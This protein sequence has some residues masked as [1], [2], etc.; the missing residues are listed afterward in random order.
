MQLSIGENHNKCNATLQAPAKN[1][2]EKKGIM[3][4]FLQ[5]LMP[6]KEIDSDTGNRILGIG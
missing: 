3:A 4:G 5:S 6:E 2:N 1:A